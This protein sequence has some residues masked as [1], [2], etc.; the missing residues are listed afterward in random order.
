[1][2]AS[3]RT[4]TMTVLLFAMNRCCD[5]DRARIATL[6]ASG[7]RC[8]TVSDCIHTR[9]K[10]HL[11][12]DF[13]EERGWGEVLSFV[14]MWCSSNPGR[15]IAFLDYFWLEVDYFKNRYGSDWYTHKVDSLLRAGVWKV[16][17]PNSPEL[18]HSLGQL[19]NGIRRRLRSRTMLSDATDRTLLPKHRGEIST[20]I[21]RLLHPPFILFEDIT[22]TFA[23]PL[24]NNPNNAHNSRM[25]HQ[26][27]PTTGI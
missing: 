2:A 18:S 12:V 17:L 9:N 19:H 13:K 5:S 20:H 25:H 4:Q 21:S 8:I 23:R 7:L 16:F 11:T 15:L 3:S 22:S 27:P 6:E 10:E 14:R 1:M 26:C 24:H